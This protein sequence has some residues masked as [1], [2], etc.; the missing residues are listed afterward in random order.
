MKLDPLFWRGVLGKHHFT[1]KENIS[2]EA[3]AGWSFLR[4]FDYFRA[5]PDY[6]SKGAPYIKLEMSIGL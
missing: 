6:K 2:L 5:G 3:T 4:D 1:P